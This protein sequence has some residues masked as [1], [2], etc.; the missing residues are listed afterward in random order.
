VTVS[1]VQSPGSADVVE[2]ATS[3]LATLGPREAPPDGPPAIVIV[4]GG[5]ALSRWP[6]H[7][8]QEQLTAA[9]EQLLRSRHEWLDVPG[10]GRQVHDLCVKVLGY[11]GLPRAVLKTLA[12]A[13]IIQI[14]FP[15]GASPAALG[16]PWE[17]ALAEATQPFRKVLHHRLGRLFLVYR[18][19][20]SL[21][22]ANQP[23]PL[24]PPASLL[25]VD[26]AP[27]SISEVYSFESERRLVESSLDLEKSESLQDPDRHHMRARVTQMKPAVIHLAGVDGRQGHS[28]LGGVS[29]ASAAPAD[30]MYF[31]GP[32]ELDVVSFGDLAA[33]VTAGGA[34]RLVAYNIH[35][36]AL[37]AAEAVKLGAAAAIGIQYDLD[38]S[39][40]E[41]F[42]A[43]FYGEWKRSGWDLVAGFRGAFASLGSYAS[44]VRGTGIVLWTRHSLIEA[45]GTGS[46]TKR[47]VTSSGTGTGTGGTG[48]VT[49]KRP[50][51]IADASEYLEVEYDAPSELNYSLLH[52]NANIVPKLIIRRQKPGTYRGISVEV[53]VQAGTE[54]ASYRTTLSLHD[55]RQREDLHAKIRVPL[56]S[57]L[58][59]TLDESMFSTIYVCVRWGRHVLIEDT[60]QVKFM[61]VDQWRYDDVNARWLPSFVFPRDP[62]VRDIIST[63]HRYLLALRDDG[64]AGFD[65]YQS[66]EPKESSIADRSRNIDAQVQAIWWALVND[67]AVGYINPPPNFTD[68]AQR[69]RTPSEII[70]GRRG[71]CID[72]ALLLAACLEYVEI[73][74]VVFLLNDH[75]FPGYWRSDASYDELGKLSL[76]T[77]AT[78]ADSDPVPIAER[79][80]HIDAWM[81]GRA[82]FADVT[83]LVAQGH[84]VPIESVSLTSR[85]GFW[86]SVDEGVGNLRSRRQFH[87]LFDLRTSRKKVT[88][89]P[90]WSKRV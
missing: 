76:A 13:G 18:H 23:L 29:P 24:T 35:N 12:S 36:S 60:H 25:V 37:G 38:D 39:V 1:A 51:D 74:P 15:A 83:R 47:G 64:S 55:K 43:N 16:F 71:T 56:T 40:A 22:A 59:R 63:A 79:E 32:A 9:A 48:S 41:L 5:E 50:E 70:G 66:Y 81:L 14:S 49:D 26:S 17:F 54:Q 30:G 21:P 67:Y 75:A 82:R 80:A 4:H 87:S 19:V 28:L 44:K 45:A 65:G 7:A 52:N 85:S 53:T 88:P 33:I 84:I 11:L 31:A 62:V 61:P 27:G 77:T 58:I 57:A 90:I 86:P 69:L 8:P 6:L 34:L 42:F 20:P 46:G 3:L 78:A 89:I 10:T 2:T 73:Y 68:D 72:L